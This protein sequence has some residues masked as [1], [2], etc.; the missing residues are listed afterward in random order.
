MSGFHP[1][2]CIFDRLA[3]SEFTGE[4]KG[5][6]SFLMIK[7]AGKLPAIQDAGETPALQ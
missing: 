4:G 7:N 1:W 5:G 6:T 3:V 2:L